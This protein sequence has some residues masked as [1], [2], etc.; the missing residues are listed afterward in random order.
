MNAARR[1]FIHQSL[2]V[3]GYVALAVAVVPVVAVTSVYAYRAAAAGYAH[4]SYDAGG[5]FAA[6]EAALDATYA[7]IGAPKVTYDAA[8]AA[9]QA[10]ER[11]DEEA[12]AACDAAERARVDSLSRVLPVSVFSL[13]PLAVAGACFWTRRFLALGDGG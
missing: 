6:F 1:R 7:A 10:A 12:Q 8:Y 2:G 3:A 13:A 5:T 9:S 11:A 4:K